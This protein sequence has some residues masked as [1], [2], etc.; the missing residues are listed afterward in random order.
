M[1]SETPASRISCVVQL[2]T[3]IVGIAGENHSRCDRTRFIS[4]LL[5]C[6][7]Q[8]AGSYRRDEVPG[9]ENCVTLPIV[10]RP[11][12][13]SV[14]YFAGQTGIDSVET[15]VGSEQTLRHVETLLSCFGCSF[16][17]QSLCI[18]A[19]TTYHHTKRICASNGEKLSS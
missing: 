6:N 4:F 16:A 3:G 5:S 14:M 17:P 11:N 12:G 15:Y 9:G 7:C 1:A 13:H 2:V 19:E 18:V 10:D 8:G